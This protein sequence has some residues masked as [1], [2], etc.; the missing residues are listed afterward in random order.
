MILKYYIEDF[1]LLWNDDNIIFKLIINFIILRTLRT[2]NLL[3]TLL[4][5]TILFI[6]NNN[7]QH[8]NIIFRCWNNI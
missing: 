8:I 1:I 6:N 4:I 7:L 3:V 2:I 5:S